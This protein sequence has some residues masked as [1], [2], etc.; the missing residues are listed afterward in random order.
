MVASGLPGGAATGMLCSFS[1]LCSSSTCLTT[2]T[3]TCLLELRTVLPRNW[4]LD[5]MV[6]AMS[7][8]PFS[9][10]IHL[11]P[12]PWVSGQTVRN[13]KMWLPCVSPYGAQQPPLLL[14]QIVSLA[15][16]SLVWCLV[17]VRLAIFLPVLP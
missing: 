6:L 11:V 10:S 13:A 8:R 3:A 16:F 14:W 17:S 1:G 12:F 9:L 7:H 4:A 15:S 2:W 5:L